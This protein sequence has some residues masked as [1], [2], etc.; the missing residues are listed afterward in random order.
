MLN[1]SKRKKGVLL[2]VSS[3]LF[4]QLMTVVCGF[5]LPPLIIS[6]FGSVMNG[7]VSSIKQFIAYLNIVEAGVGGAAIAAMYQPLADKDVPSQNGIL[8]ASC[9]F[10]N[11]S[12]VLFVALTSC[13]A[14]VYPLIVQSE[15]DGKTAGLMVLVLGIPGVAEFFL[16]GKYRVLLTADKHLYVVSFVRAGVLILNTVVSVVLICLGVGLVAV[17][18]VASLIF[19]SRYFVIQWYVSRKYP[20][21]DFHAAP[22]TGAISQSRSVLVHQIGGLVV[23]NAPLVLLTIFCSLKDVSVYSVY[24]MVFSGVNSVLSAFSGGMQSFFGESLVSEDLGQTRS[25]FNRYENVFLVVMGWMYSMTF[26][27]VM[28]FM[29]LYTKNMTDADYIQPLLAVLLVIAGV[30]NQL[31]KPCDLLISAAGHYEQTRWHSIV[32]VIINLAASTFFTLQLGFTGVVLGSLCSYTYRTLDIIVYANKKL[33]KRKPG[34][35]LVKTALVLCVFALFLYFLS[36]VDYFAVDSLATWIIYAF[37][38]G[39]IL[40]VPAFLSLYVTSKFKS[41]E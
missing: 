20:W 6:R 14:I 32:E 33:L 7:M 21:L 38:L 19:L 8:S 40:G 28:P 27:L 5:I 3:S 16:I 1:L 13:L 9:K 34:F 31:R 39:V 36:F 25:I 24:A 26:V 37:V 4:L 30:A 11:K 35:S 2:T 15:I 22:D 18:L 17:N 29:Q 23:F 41:K 10:Y 12:G